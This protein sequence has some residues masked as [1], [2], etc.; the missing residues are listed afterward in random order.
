MRRNQSRRKHRQG[1]STLVEFALVAPYLLIIFFATVGLGLVMGR[2]IQA[3]QVCRDIAH[4]Y[5]DGLDFT[6]PTM[7][8]IA[9]QLASGTGMT[10][11]GGNGVIILSRI[12]TVYQADCNSA[13]YPNTCNNL[14]NQ[15]ITQRIVVGNSS[16]RQSSF[17]TPT[18]S[19]MDGSGNI[20][21]SVYL[22]NTDPSVVATGF[23]AVLTAASETLVQ[24]QAVYMAEV[25]FAYP[26][27]SY[28]FGCVYCQASVGNGAYARFIY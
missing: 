12:V 9:L 7:Q 2:Y 5:S 10:A 28:L 19:L 21:P 1:G 27:I 23:G 6:K 24:G 4:M 14:N 17:G 22:Q 18:A 26:D 15:V 8:N 13:G 11:N 25:Y 3:V 20:S 16:L